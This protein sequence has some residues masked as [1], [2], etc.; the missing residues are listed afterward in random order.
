MFVFLE[1]CL[2]KLIS[3]I[4]KLV[5]LELAVKVS[6]VKQDKGVHGSNSLEGVRSNSHLHHPDSQSLFITHFST[7]TA[8]V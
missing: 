1:D 6:L 3:F 4:L 8:F 2:V 7:L 5:E